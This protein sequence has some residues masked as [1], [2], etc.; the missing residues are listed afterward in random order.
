MSRLSKK[1]RHMNEEFR[2][3]RLKHRDG[4]PVRK[5]STAHKMARRA[6]GSGH[7]R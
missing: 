1:I 7:R 5:K 3:G 2:A 4:N 6:S